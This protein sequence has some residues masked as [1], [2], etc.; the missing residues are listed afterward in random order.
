M[1]HLDTDRTAFLSTLS[2]NPD[3]IRVLLMNELYLEFGPSSD[4]GWD[5][6]MEMRRVTDIQIGDEEVIAFLIGV[7]YKVT[8]EEFQDS[9]RAVHTH[10]DAERVRALLY[11]YEIIEQKSAN[12]E[13][14]VA[15]W[16][17]YTLCSVV[18]ILTVVWFII[19]S[20]LKVV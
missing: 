19:S 18:A 8:I 4:R 13:E 5:D 1:I 10:A 15:R 2:K 17:I 20:V 11:G 6:F 3:L 9:C 14:T 16:V 12:L 7:T